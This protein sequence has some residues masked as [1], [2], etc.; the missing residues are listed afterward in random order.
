[1]ENGVE[2]NDEGPKFKNPDHVRISNIRAFLQRAILQIGLKK[3]L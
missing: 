1:M 3:F 2:N